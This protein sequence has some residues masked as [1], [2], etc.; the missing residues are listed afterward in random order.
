MFPDRI[1]YFLTHAL[2]QFTY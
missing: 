1:L 2:C